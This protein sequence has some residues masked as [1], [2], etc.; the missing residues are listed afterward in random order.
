MLYGACTISLGDEIVDIAG[1]MLLV[2][3]CVITYCHLRMSDMANKDEVAGYSNSVSLIHYDL[4]DVKECVVNVKTMQLL[5]LQ[6]RIVTSR[7]PGV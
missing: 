7:K 1:L 4:D 2:Y 5:F 3:L 6:N